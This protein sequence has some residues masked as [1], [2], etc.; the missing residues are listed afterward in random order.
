MIITCPHCSTR[1][2]VAA[3]ALGSVGRKV[4]CARC[5]GAW[6]A[7]PPA[8]APAPAL[9]LVPKADDDLLF[10]P[11]AEQR[12]D[13]AFEAEAERAAPAE[14][15]TR[16]APKPEAATGPIDLN[17]LRQAQ[18]AF[19]QRRISKNRS[20]PVARMRRA[21]R[22]VGLVLL[23]G[24]LV[25]LLIFRDDTV[26][27]FPDL[28]GL[29]EVIGLPVNIVGLEFSDMRTLYSLVDGREVLRVSAL[30]TAVA[31]G[32]TT[33][34]PV[35]VTLLDAHQTPL[36]GWSVD[37]GAGTLMGGEVVQFET[38]LTKPPADAVRVMLAFA[39]A[40]TQPSPRASLDHS[41]LAHEMPPESHALTQDTL[42]G[43]TAA[44]H[45]ASGDAHEAS[46]GQ[47]QASGAEQQSAHEESGSGG[48]H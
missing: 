26:R 13:A 22:L 29:Y 8:P 20:L 33:V 10:D 37:P 30:L 25:R 31:S 23:T 4:Q 39:S 24:L 9:T 48:H 38:Q 34:P 15:V 14:S 43:P 11:T 5:R 32:E 46:H 19:F 6:N 17:A 7:A 45:E 12:L 2:Q 18:K 36:Y 41:E 42:D 35:L 21:A 47:Q 44:V 3:E 28:A 27:Q 1:Y 40:P 16:P